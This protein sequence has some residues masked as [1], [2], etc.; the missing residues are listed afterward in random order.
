MMFVFKQ[1][2]KSIVITKAYPANESQM[3]CQSLNSIVSKKVINNYSAE[4]PTKES[5]K[6]IDIII[7]N[8]VR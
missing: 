3:L 8:P 5:P 2:R 6:S 7:N 4:N 1:Q